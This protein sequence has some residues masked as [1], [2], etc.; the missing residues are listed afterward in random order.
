MLPSKA[1]TT[2]VKRVL[3]SDDPVTPEMPLYAIMT[4][5][6]HIEII[7]PH[8]IEDLPCYTLTPGGLDEIQNPDRLPMDALPHI[9]VRYEQ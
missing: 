3:D 5:D 2:R 8:A 9:E 1:I 6:G 7:D 4:S